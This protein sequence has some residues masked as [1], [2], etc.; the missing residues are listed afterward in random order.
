MTVTCSNSRPPRKEMILGLRTKVPEP[1]CWAQGCTWA[2]TAGMERWGHVV[3]H[4][5]PDGQ[6]AA[7]G[8]THLSQINGEPLPLRLGEL[9]IAVSILS[10][11]SSIS[12]LPRSASDERNPDM[13][14]EVGWR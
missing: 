8:S 3:D 10:P 7:G 6:A 9:F 1:G 12:L 4:D 13:S 5:K 11:Q 2:A 14:N